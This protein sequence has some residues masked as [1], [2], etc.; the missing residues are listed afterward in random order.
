MAQLSI[1]LMGCLRKSFNIGVKT[2]DDWAG[3][4]VD[5]GFG[6]GVTVVDNM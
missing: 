3:I 1:F 5:I 2:R 6:K 4:D